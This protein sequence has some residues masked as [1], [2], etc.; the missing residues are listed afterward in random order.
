MNKFYNELSQVVRTL[1]TM[2]KI[3]TAEAHVYSIIS[4]SGTVRQSYYKMTIIVK[5]GD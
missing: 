4:K 5:T 3:N 1:N 2:K